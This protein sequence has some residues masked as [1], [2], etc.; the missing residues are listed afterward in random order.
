MP[1]QGGEPLCNLLTQRLRKFLE[2]GIPAREFQIRDRRLSFP[3]TNRVAVS[4]A[5]SRAKLDIVR[6][7]FDGTVH[8]GVCGNDQF[9]G[10][11]ELALLSKRASLP[12]LGNCCV[13]YRLRLLASHA[14]DQE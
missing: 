13:E 10:R 12:Q 9:V 2:S 5:S 3:G 6:R 7:G 8:L 1:G 14:Q 11:A 4:D